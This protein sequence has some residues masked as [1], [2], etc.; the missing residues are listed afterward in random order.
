[1]ERLD[2][3]TARFTAQVWDSNELVPWIRTFL[4][5]ITSI[6]FTNPAVDKRFRA[7]VAAMYRLYGM[8]DDDALS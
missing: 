2:A 8:E 4:C 3:H 6:H 5:R 1:M 7:D